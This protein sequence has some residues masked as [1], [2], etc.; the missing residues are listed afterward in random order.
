MNKVQSFLSVSEVVLRNKQGKLQA[1]KK[2]WTKFKWPEFK[3]L[4]YTSLAQVSLVISVSELF[5]GTATLQPRYK[6]KSYTVLQRLR[7]VDLFRD[8]TTSAIF[9]GKSLLILYRCISVINLNSINRHYRFLISK[10]N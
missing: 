4:P 9:G 10:V 3:E 7:N 8:L 6:T 5:A 1:G 2:G